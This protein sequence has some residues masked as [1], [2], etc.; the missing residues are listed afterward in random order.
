M[1]TT[2][3]A[4]VEATPDLKNKA[5]SPAFMQK[6]LDVAMAAITEAIANDTDTD[7]AIC[8]AVVLLLITAVSSAL[9]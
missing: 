1:L 4:Y 5:R 2:L 3:V 6:H 7:D 9:L 8:F